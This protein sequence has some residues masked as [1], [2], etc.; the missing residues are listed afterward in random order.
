MSEIPTSK[1][2]M[3]TE[4]LK[5]VL[6]LPTMKL[7]RLTGKALLKPLSVGITLTT[8]CNLNCPF[9]YL[10]KTTE[11]ENNLSKQ[12][13]IDFITYLVDWGVKQI[14]FSGGEPLLEKNF[15][16]LL[17]FAKCREM[18][19][20]FSTNGT[21]LTDDNIDRLRN[22]GVD[23]ISV[24]IDGIKKTHDAF[25]GDGVYERAISGFKRL[26]RV[27]KLNL[28]INT[29]ILDQ[30]LNELVEL[31]HIARTYGAG[32]NLMPLTDPWHVTPY[33][34]TKIEDERFKGFWVKE[35]NFPLLDQTL[36]Q[37]KKLKQRYGVL[38]NQD[39]FLNLLKSYY[40][41]PTYVNR[42]CMVATYSMSLLANGYL[43]ICGP[44]GVLGNIRDNTPKQL[45][46]SERFK[47]A[48]LRMKNCNECLL[49]CQYTPSVYELF[50]DFIFHPIRRKIR[51]F[52]KLSQ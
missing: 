20:G 24:S 26:S 30:N 35:E 9:C 46:E 25:R 14:T 23:R 52:T 43:V 37:L 39:N 41:D 40:R 51:G 27:K 16:E 8:K 34:N 31:F 22:I 17:E 48:R 11:F 33:K 5:Y 50:G 42:K 19:V 45:W 36:D 38:L 18:T 32:F 2:V 6:N 21:L 12:E 10:D 4:G 29:I 13:F 44:L 3:F 28:R 49:N 15:F 1:K 7:S 47:K